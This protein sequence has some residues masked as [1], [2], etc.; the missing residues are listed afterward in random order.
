MSTST[1]TETLAIHG[2]PKAVTR[3]LNRYKGAAA[4][5][6]E[7]K[8]AV[9]E[10]LESRSLFRYYGPDLRYK[11]AG[12][13]AAFA[14]Y[15]DVPYVAACSSGTAA[16]RIALA[17][18]GVGAG[19]EVIVPAVTFIASVGAVVAQ[20]ALPIFA[21]VD[22]FLTLDPLAIEPLLTERTRAI[23]PVHLNGIACDMDGIMQ[24]ARRHGIAVVEDTAQACGSFYKERRLG[25]IG[26]IGAF[27]FQLEKNITSGEGGAISTA[28]EEL[29]K[30]AV[31]YS[32]QGGQFPI[33]SG[34]IRDLVG[35]EPF[36][37]ENLRMTE[38]AG[39]IL[40]CQLERLDGMLQRLERA[41]QLVLQGIR[42]LPLHFGPSDASRDRHALGVGFSLAHATQARSFVEALQAEGVPA[43]LVYG[44]KPV[45]ANRQIIEQR[46][47]TRSCPFYCSCTDHRRVSYSLGMCLRTEDLL[48]RYVGV[49]LGPW[50][51]DQ[52]L[53]D[54]VHG[55]RKVAT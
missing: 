5:G 47:L 40:G 16:L 7:E 46:T 53:G 45:Y 44:G 34:G 25:T 18:L 2:G 35:G 17:A 20:G 6:D 43:G 22:E 32:D 38:I 21:E 12:F 14:R 37:G 29:Y 28:D 49:G 26:D 27:S 19:D 42:D 55:I 52:D 54:I 30:R 8:R 48:G 36:L 50:Y 33:Q 23:M 24:V 1:S 3:P 13:E 11:V 15:L 31:K 10:V 51:D 41:R 4:I 39:A 9:M